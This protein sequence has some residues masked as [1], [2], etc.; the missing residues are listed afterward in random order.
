[1]QRSIR[2]RLEDI[3]EAIDR[4]SAFING[5]RWEDFASDRMLRD[6]VERNI[7][8]IS[9]A[10]RYIPAE[11]RETFPEIQWRGIADI[12]NVLRHGYHRI[13]DEAIWQV[14]MRDLPPLRAVIGAMIA[15]IESGA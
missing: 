7:E 10:S 8:I 9:E 2:Q 15:D 13:D 1:M 14:S 12:G 5:R 6:A 11:L 4:V 3:I